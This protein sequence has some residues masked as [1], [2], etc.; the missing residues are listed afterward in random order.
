MLLSGRCV[1]CI[2]LHG[3]FELLLLLLLWMAVPDRRDRRDRRHRSR[4]VKRSSHERHLIVLRLVKGRLGV[5]ICCCC[6]R[7]RR[8]HDQGLGLLLLLLVARVGSKQM[9][10]HL[11]V[12]LE[13]SPGLLGEESR[14]VEQRGIRQ[15]AR[16]VH[17]WALLELGCH[18]HVDGVLT[19]N[20]DIDE[21]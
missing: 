19:I 21:N 4:R 8:R 20:H 9:R 13:C 16:R 18:E 14:H 6:R 2:S 10:C 5:R 12:A 11:V 3:E 7:R 17:L 15:F 1:F